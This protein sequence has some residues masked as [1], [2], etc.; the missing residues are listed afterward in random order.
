[1]IDL[2]QPAIIYHNESLCTKDFRDSDLEIPGYKFFVSYS[3][4]RDTGG[5]NI[6]VEA[7]F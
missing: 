4:S 7:Q 1:M 6:F 3:D 5:V 2:I